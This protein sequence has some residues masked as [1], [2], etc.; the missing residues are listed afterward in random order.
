MGRGQ[1]GKRLG[2]SQEGSI[3]RGQTA[4]IHGNQSEIQEDRE[5]NNDN[6]TVEHQKWTQGQ[7]RGGEEY[8]FFVLVF[9]KK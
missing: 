7:G 6:G 2:K 1:E 4:V 9:F 5:K 3:G 8:C